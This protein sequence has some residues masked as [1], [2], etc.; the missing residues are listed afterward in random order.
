MKCARLWFCGLLSVLASVA[1]ASANS[2]KQI[3]DWDI[4][5]ADGICQAAAEYVDGTIIS[6]HAAKASG[7]A[8]LLVTQGR[9]TNIEQGR[10]YSVT[11]FFDRI[12]ADATGRG[13]AAPSKQ[14]RAIGF[15]LNATGVSLF[16]NSRR[17]Y[18]VY[19]G[20]NAL[21]AD[22]TGTAAVIS[23]LRNCQRTFGWFPETSSDPF[24]R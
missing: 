17:M 7:G 10:E 16:G 18:I 22:L 11:M 1:P 8:A 9:W 2:W 14:I 21:A 23:E 5:V 6:L 19:K 13:V 24:R 12:R 15:D 20:E 4:D 3:G